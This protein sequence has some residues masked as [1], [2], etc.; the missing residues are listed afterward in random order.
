MWTIS[1]M[2]N[3]NVFG[4]RERNTKERKTWILMN[5]FGLKLDQI[6]SLES[7]FFSL[8]NFFLLNQAHLTERVIVCSFSFII[9]HFNLYDPI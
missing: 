1:P 4:S 9:M 5:E 8:L 6:H 7:V 2:L 3:V